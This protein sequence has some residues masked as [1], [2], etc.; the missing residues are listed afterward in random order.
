MQFQ[1]LDDGKWRVFL[2]VDEFE[3]MLQ[4]AE[5]QRARTVMFL[6]AISLRVKT[7]ANLLVG[8]FYQ[9]DEG[10]WWVHIEAKDATDRDRE[11]KP[12]E[13]RV[14]R[15]VIEEVESHLGSD[16]DKLPGDT[17]VF[18]VVKRT[19]QRDIEDAR[20]N[21]AIATGTENYLKISSHDFRRYYASHYLYRLGVDK[22]AVRQMG[23]W[24]KVEHM[25]EYLLLPRDL[26]KNRLAEAGVLGQNPL[27][28]TNS[29]PADQ[30]DA[31]FDTIE[32]LGYQVDSDDVNETLQDRLLELGEEVD[33][34]RVLLD[35]RDAGSSEDTVS[36]DEATRQA[37]FSTDFPDDESGIIDL[38]MVAKAAYVSTVVAGSWT[39][40]LAPLF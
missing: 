4:S 25:V 22:H 37:S 5:G 27:T 26:L 19:L 8:Q 7:A 1:P 21:A 30:V 14:P 6:M 24:K 39:V 11:T 31:N 16:L 9:D 35:D 28:M 29:G 36:T 34:V 17:A 23:G 38:I 3:Q 18:N 33:G 12:R 32:F 2:R 13:V 15:S 10:F 20:E 40:T